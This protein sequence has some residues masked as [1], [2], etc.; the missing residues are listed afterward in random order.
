MTGFIE[1][2]FVLIGAYSLLLVVFF[3]IYR[4]LPFRSLPSMVTLPVRSILLIIA[5]TIGCAVLISKSF[6][7][8]IVLS[9]YF[10]D[11]S[12][13]GYLLSLPLII[14]LLL[15]IIIV[16]IFKVEKEIWLHQHPERS[17][18]ILQSVNK[19][20]H[21]EGVSVRSIDDI[22]NGRGVSF[23]WFD[24]RFI[25]SG[26]HRVTFEFFTYGKL[27]RNNTKRIIY[28]KDI[29]MKFISGIVYIVEAKPENNT[30]HITR[31]TKKSV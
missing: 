20:F 25:A 28:T 21:A 9:Q 8:D 16:I 22:N 23:S 5:V 30:F 3:L 10:S 17:R 13:V 26:K 15:M 14:M 7:Y 27:K 1:Y 31:D 18:L 12:P 11:I 6:K 29:T 24:G 19:L 4:Y 2:I